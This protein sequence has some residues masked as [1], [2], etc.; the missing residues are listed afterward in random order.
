MPI[1]CLACLFALIFRI[2]FISADDWPQW[3]GPNRDAVWH[4]DGILKSFPAGGLKFL[5]RVQVHEGFSSPIVVQ[6]RVYLTDVELTYPNPQERVLC[7]DAATGQPLWTHA[8]PAA[9]EDYGPENPTQGPISTPICAGGKLYSIGYSELHCRDAVTGNLLWKKELD[10]EYGSQPRLSWAS[11]LI[12]GQHLIIYSGRLS[13]DPVDC[14]IAIDKDSGQTVWR[15]I[16]DFSA[17]SSPI[18][19][20][21]AGKRQVIVWSQQAVTAVDAATGQILWREATR[22][23]NQSSVV[24]T[25]VTLGNQLLIAAL[26]MELDQAQPAAKVLWPESKSPARRNFS[27]TSSPMLRGDLVFSGR[28]SGE[29][30]CLDAATGDQL[31]SDEKVTELGRGAT[32]HLTA[33]GDETFLYTDRGE[34]IIARLDRDGCHEVSRTKVL[35]PT[36]PF[37][38]SKF[39]WAPPAFANRCLFARSDKELV[40][41]SLAE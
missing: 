26:M 27:M 37:S 25:P 18:V 12:E 17:A 32:I 31:W 13:E 6:G 38:G 33:H 5:W 21:A 11:P 36:Y 24:A 16:K 30:V 14:L 29:L 9:Y 10:K 41:A 19:V 35:E 7:F 1:R 8:Y 34:L 22:P 28:T 39:A 23:E 20:S 3:R 4:E 40:C 15:A 2:G